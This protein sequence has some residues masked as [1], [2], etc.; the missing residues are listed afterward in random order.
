[1]VTLPPTVTP[2]PS[3]TPIPQPPARISK[4]GFAI[5]INT[6]GSGVSLRGGPGTNNDRL[7]VVGE[8][9]VVEV[10]DDYQVSEN[11]DDAIEHPIWWHV[12]APDGQDGW[13]SERFLQ[14]SLTPKA[15]IQ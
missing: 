13:V 10:I 9:D 14:P 4:N 7:G 2:V 5:I 6:D 12:K 15:K 8:G 11:R 3:D 1:V